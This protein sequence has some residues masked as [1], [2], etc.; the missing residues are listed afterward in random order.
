MFYFH[1]NRAGY[2]KYVG[3]IFKKCFGNSIAHL[4]RRMIADVSHRIYSLPG[5]T[6]SDQH[7][8]IKEFHNK[9]FKKSTS[10]NYGKADAG[11]VGHTTFI[12]LFY[13]LFYQPG[14]QLETVVHS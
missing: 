8:F 5:W 13:N 1:I 12:Y 10:Q 6:G 2:Q 4:S 11:F 14:S 9:S 7:L 3:S